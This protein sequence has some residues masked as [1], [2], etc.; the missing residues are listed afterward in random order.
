MEI[1]KVYDIFKLM[2]LKLIFN[3]LNKKNPAN[4]YSLYKL[5]TLKNDHNTRS[6]FVDIK[7]SVTTRT[8]FIPTART[9]HC[10]LK[11]LKVQGSKIW[12][13]LQPSLRIIDTI[14]SFIK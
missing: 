7:N 13:K 9:S 1:L 4:F 3:C 10:G 14:Y 6:K 11:L 5:T 8:L 12:N 2:I